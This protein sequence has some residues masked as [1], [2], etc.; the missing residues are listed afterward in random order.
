MSS[1]CVKRLQ[2]ELRGINK[3]HVPYCVVAPAPKNMLEWHYVL[4]PPEGTPYQDGEYH[5]RIVFPPQYP[6][7]PPAIFMDTPSG[8]F[9]PGKSI[10]LSMS[11]YHPEQW[12]PLWCASTILSALLSFMVIYF[13]N[14]FEILIIFFKI[15]NIYCI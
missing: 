5:G 10:C 14:G 4:F 1:G 2:K 13:F 3:E 6:Y 9:T 8:R 15:S 12:N 7:K 11:E